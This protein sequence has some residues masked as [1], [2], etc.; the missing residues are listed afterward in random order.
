MTKNKSEILGSNCP[1]KML[2]YFDKIFIEFEQNDNISYMNVD[3]RKLNNT[4][5]LQYDAIEVTRKAPSDIDSFN[6]NIKLFKDH[7]PKEY[8]L[9]DKLAN[10]LKITQGNIIKINNALWMY[11]KLNR[12]QDR[13]KINFTG[14][15]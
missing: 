6:V 8:M 14:G 2:Q 9:S 1:I 12:L 11:I 3:W 10:V 5:D 4:D 13:D 7:R 15:K